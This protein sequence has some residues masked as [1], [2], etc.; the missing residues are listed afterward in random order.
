MGENN[1]RCTTG[2]KGIIDQIFIDGKLFNTF[3]GNIAVSDGIEAYAEWSEFRSGLRCVLKITRVAGSRNDGAEVR[4]RIPYVFRQYRMKVWTARENFPKSLVELGGSNIFYGDVCYGTTLPLVTLINPV[5]KTGLTIGR[6]PMRYGGTL[7]F[8][9]ETYHEEGMEIRVS[10][11]AVSPGET[12]EQEF[13]FFGHEDCWRPGL[14]KYVEM[15]P[16]YFEAPLAAVNSWGGAF[17]ITNPFTKLDYS[18]QLKP[19]WVEIHNHFP[20]YGEYAPECE[21][22]TSVIP[23]DYPEL[24]DAHDYQV[25]K[26]LIN[27]HIAELHA[28]NIRA[29]L[30]IQVSG[31]GFMPWAEKNFPESIAREVSG[32]C[33]PTWKN[34]CFMNGDPDT[35]FGR[36]IE[37]MIDRFNSFYPDIDGVFLDQLCY[38]TMDYAHCDGKSADKGQAVYEY[39]ASYDRNLSKLSSLMHQSG[40]AILANGPFD[41]GAAK[42]VD[43]V[44]AEGCS[45]ISNTLKYLCICKPMLVHSYT[46]DVSQVETALRNCLL[47]GAGWSLGGSS[48][49]AEIPQWSDEVTRTFELYLPLIKSIYGKKILL[50]ANPVKFAPAVP[51]VSWEIF[52]DKVNG[53]VYVALIS[54][55]NRLYHP[56]E[57]SLN[58]PFDGRVS[59]MNLGETTFTSLDKS[60]A[61]SCILPEDFIACVLKYSKE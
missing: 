13:F 7:S 39:G 12:V 9:F 56:V 22:W 17:A 43:A 38:Q 44:M 45:G 16:E 28:K 20:Y 27:Q 50:E 47:S 23:H 30:Y 33:M 32:E 35:P 10:R 25:S 26:E 29:M 53:D 48:T 42:Y 40:K 31:D 51:D 4:F 49:L 18:K 8:Y 55:S 58:L 6:N 21:T 41:L 24:A 54:D 15:F 14:K 36:H 11:L 46:K 60:A 37:C 5:E 3:R 1:I 59:I 19:D 57:I 61:G 52:A 34:C 2:D